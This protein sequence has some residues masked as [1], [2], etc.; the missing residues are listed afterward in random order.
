MAA[1][2]SHYMAFSWSSHQL[3]DLGSLGPSR[4]FRKDAVIVEQSPLSNCRIS[5]RPSGETPF[6]NK[7]TPTR[8][9]HTQHEKWGGVHRPQVGGLAV[10]CLELL[11]FL[12]APPLPTGDAGTWAAGGGGAV[13]PSLASPHPWCPVQGSAHRPVHVE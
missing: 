13:F 4:L 9:D 5:A 12:P 11:L 1:S 6:P 8:R 2:L 7:V 3:P 10:W